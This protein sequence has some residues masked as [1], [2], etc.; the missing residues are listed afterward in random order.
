MGNYYQPDPHIHHRKERKAKD[1][2][3]DLP[4]FH[5]KDDVD[6]FLDWEM[7]VEQLF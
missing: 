6:I 3:V 2:G 5:G 7:K 1:V 4:H